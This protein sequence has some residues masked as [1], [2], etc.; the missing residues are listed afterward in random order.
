MDKLNGFEFKECDELVSFDVCSLFTNVPLD[1]T[2][3]LISDCVYGDESKK[4]PP[5]PKK[6]VHKIVEICN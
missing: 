4:V 6:V 2:I 5:F 3:S 1:E